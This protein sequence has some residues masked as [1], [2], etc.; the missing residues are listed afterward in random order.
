M[1]T[2]F[3]LASHTGWAGNKDDFKHLQLWRI[4]AVCRHPEC[5]LKGISWLVCCCFLAVWLQASA[6]KQQANSKRTARNQ[7]GTSN[8]RVS[9][10]LARSDNSTDYWLAGSYQSAPRRGPSDMQAGYKRD[11]NGR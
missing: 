11:I 10:N 2:V 9:I 8:K 1:L 5:C 6:R 7:Q 3:R 4:I